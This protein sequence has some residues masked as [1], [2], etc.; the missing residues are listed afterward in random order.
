[1]PRVR[2]ALILSFCV[3]G[4][5]RVDPPPASAPPPPPTPISVASPPVHLPVARPPVEP[6]KVVEAK[7]PG[8]VIAAPLPRGVHSVRG[9]LVDEDQLP[10]PPDPD[11]ASAYQRWRVGLAA[12]ARANVDVFCAANRWSYHAACGGI[13]P[14]HI[15]RPPSLAAAVGPHGGDARTEHVAWEAALSPA[16]RRYYHYWCVDHTDEGEIGFSELCGGT[17]LV[18][19]FAADARVDFAPDH[20]GVSAATPWLARDLDHDGTIRGDELFGDATLLPDGHRA[21]DGFTALA[22]LDA[23]HD[24]VIDAADPAFAELVL[25]REGSPTLEPLAA[26][27]IT[28][29]SLASA[30]VPRCTALGCE[31]ERAAMTLA[32]GGTGAVIDVYFPRRRALSASRASP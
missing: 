23:N 8:A 20:L 31:G 7:A 22:A 2:A 21:R 19:A 32:G 17:P 24:G 30:R 16:Q 25:Y 5:E 18:V 12:Q 11:D 3:V 14:L 4:C 27:G 15:P 13:G 10:Q 26:A 9:V 1:M 6:A 29:L 28:A